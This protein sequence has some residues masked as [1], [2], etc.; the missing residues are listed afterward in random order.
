MRLYL[1]ITKSTQTVP[2]NYQHYLTGVLHKWIGPENE[3]HDQTSLYSFSWLQQVNTNA[4]G[5]RTTDRSSFFISA[6]DDK[7]LKK[8][9][10]GIRQDPA[11]G[12]GIKVSGVQITAPP[13][14]SYKE[15]FH[16]ASPILI[17]RKLDDNEKHIEY[18]DPNASQYL[19][20][21]L[22][23]KTGNCRTTK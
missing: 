4:D 3:I 5:I 16:T 2:F 22:Q 23:K 18:N 15:V 11:I 6:Y 21:A 17:K 1:Q 12:F 8:I 14:F 10:N 9:L 7:L 20:Q 19:T 13:A